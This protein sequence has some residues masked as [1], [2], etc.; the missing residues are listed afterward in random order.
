MGSLV[1]NCT[2]PKARVSYPNLF[3]PTPNKLKNNQLEYSVQA[4]F[5]NPLS[6]AEFAQLKEC[7]RNACI[8]K[9]GTDQT[10]WPKNAGGTP[11]RLP[12]KTQ[13]E[14]IAKAKE[15][16]QSFDHLKPG[17]VYMH[18][19]TSA[20]D[21]S[22]SPRARPPVV[23]RARQPIEEP[24]KFYAGCWAK[25][26]VTAVAYSNGANHGV[27]FYLNASQF[28]GDDKAFGNRPSVESAFEAIPDDAMPATA[29]GAPASAGD[30]FS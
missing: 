25:F 23:D 15:K 11:L 8:E 27:S 3:K 16:N 9:W 19:K 29:D 14:L 6:A 1:V 7:A 21:K 12:F 28:V 5:E 10:K 24:S 17:A 30:M 22:G 18:F 26:N 20:V 13:D 4:L 2:T